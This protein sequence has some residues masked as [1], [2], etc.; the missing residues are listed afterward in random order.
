MTTSSSVQERWGVV[1]RGTD[2]D[3]GFPMCLVARE[4]WDTE[5]RRTVFKLVKRS[6]GWHNTGQYISKNRFRK[7]PEKNGAKL[8]TSRL[9]SV[10]RDYAE[11]GYSEG[12]TRRSDGLRLRVRT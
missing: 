2:P 8:S 9:D 4:K 7:S 10:L 5:T 6:N 3:T 1:G 11:Q 12:T